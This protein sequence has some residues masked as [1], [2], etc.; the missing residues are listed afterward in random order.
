MSTVTQRPRELGIRTERDGADGV[1][2]T[3]R[4]SGCGLP[5]EQPERI[6]GAFFTTKPNGLGMGLSISRT[7]VE[8]HGGKLW[9][10]SA[11]DG[12]TFQ[13]RLPVHTEA[14]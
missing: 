13:F 12:A 5:L 11:G 4:D 2:V 14:G 8:A 3:V 6:F 9:A 1:L 7:I 10:T